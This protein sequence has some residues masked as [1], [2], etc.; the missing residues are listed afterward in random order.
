LPGD[1][2]LKGDGALYRFFSVG[3]GNQKTVTEV[4]D[5]KAMK[6]LKALTK[7][8]IVSFNNPSPT[9]LEALL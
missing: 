9:P 8:G 4:L 7:K 6:T 1:G 5:L 3:E 2:L